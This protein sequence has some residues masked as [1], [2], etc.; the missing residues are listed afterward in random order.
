THI[1]LW[2]SVKQAR[3]G[4]RV[5]LLDRDNSRREVKRRL[6]AWGAAETPTF[7]V[8]TRD[9]VPPLTH[10]AA[11][12]T[13]PFADYDVVVIDSYDSS[14]EGVGEQDSGKPS[15]ALAP[16]IDI[17]HRADG[18]AILLLGNTVKSD[19]HSRGSGVIEDRG[20]LVYEVR[21]ATSFTPS[22]AKEWWIELPPGGREAWAERA[23]RR[24]QRDRIRLAFVNTKCR[25]G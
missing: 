22:G 14:T 10:A 24:G 16:M 2:L 5:L 23:M 20:D 13:F 11:W 7:H 8:M 3:R 25:I 4:L 21:D 18:P 1:A 15:R 9:E 17:A 12:R 6:H 19:K